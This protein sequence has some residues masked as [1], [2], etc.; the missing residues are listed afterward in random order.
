MNRPD[1]AFVVLGDLAQ[2]FGWNH[3]ELVKR[4]EAKRL[5]EA[6]E[7]YQNKKTSA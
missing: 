6:K 4:L 3:Q 1:R 5:T 7:Y 2:R